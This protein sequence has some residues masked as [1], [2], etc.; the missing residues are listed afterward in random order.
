MSSVWPW[1]LSLGVIG[2]LLIFV[3]FLLFFLRRTLLRVEG[4]ISEVEERLR[5][6]DPTLRVIGQIGEAFE[7]HTVH[8]KRLAE[9]TAELVANK[10]GDTTESKSCRQTGVIVDLADWVFGGL[11]LWQRFRETRR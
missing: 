4:L 1:V 5:V 9:L 8:L 3:L 11:S 6:L 2:V 10:R 7:V